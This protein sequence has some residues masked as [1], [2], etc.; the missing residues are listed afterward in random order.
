MVYVSELIGCKISSDLHLQLT[1]ENLHSRRAR[2]G[3]GTQ[4]VLL[5]GPAETL[6]STCQ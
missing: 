1:L 2:N 5:P 6:A 4:L 3:H